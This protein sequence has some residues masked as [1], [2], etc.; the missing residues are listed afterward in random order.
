MENLT[1][2]EAV[3]LKRMEATDLESV[4]SLHRSSFRDSFN[5]RLGAK[6]LSRLYDVMLHDPNSLVMVARNQTML[7]GVVTATLDVDRL[8]KEFAKRLTFEQ[9][10]NLSMRLL[11]NPS[12]L[13]NFVHERALEKPVL[14]HGQNVPACLTAIAVHPNCRHAGIGRVLVE[15]VETFI[16]EK[17]PS[18]FH[19][20]TRANN[21]VAREFYRRLGFV[22]IERR[23]KDLVLLKE[24]TE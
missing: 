13:F 3:A 18:A 8:R 20:L 7:V 6:H 24:L 2:L 1:T 23:G 4:V 16:K 10:L 5:S 17:G 9:K 15:S 19:L 14:F 12:F 21:A 22:E 11:L